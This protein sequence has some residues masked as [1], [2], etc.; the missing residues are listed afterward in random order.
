MNTWQ[1]RR[2]ADVT[3]NPQNYEEKKLNMKITVTKKRGIFHT[4]TIQCASQ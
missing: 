4:E 3:F 1:I 2:A